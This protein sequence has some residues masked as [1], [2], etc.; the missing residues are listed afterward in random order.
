MT[1]R[2]RSVVYK[3]L[4]CLARLAD[5]AFQMLPLRFDFSSN[6]VEVCLPLLRSCLE[7]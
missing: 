7:L 3:A 6:A 5:Y 2:D 1:A 4:L